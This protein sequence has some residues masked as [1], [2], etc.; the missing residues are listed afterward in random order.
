MEM[1]TLKGGT[2]LNR[3]EANHTLAARAVSAGGE[4]GDPANKHFNDQAERYSTGDLRPVYFY[5][6]ELQGHIDREY[7]PGR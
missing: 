4:S 3:C 1:T 7:K 6:D 5:R 2:R